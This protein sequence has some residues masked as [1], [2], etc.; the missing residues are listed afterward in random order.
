MVAPV[1]ADFRKNFPDLIEPIPEL[2]FFTI[3]DGRK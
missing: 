2:I 3:H 1:D